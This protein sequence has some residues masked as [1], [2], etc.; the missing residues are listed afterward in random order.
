MVGGKAAM[1]LQDRIEDEQ[2]I[3]MNLADVMIE[4][5]AVES[6]LLR[7]EKL[8]SLKGEEA[9]ASQIAMAKI[10]LYEAVDKIEA[11]AK[12]AIVSFAKGDEQKV[13]LMGLKRY[14]KPDFINVKELRRQVADYMIAQGKYPF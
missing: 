3:M 9:C 1:A 2:E 12:E 5:Y 6:A 14:T 10:Y 8:V 4:I 13:L 7:S 11:A